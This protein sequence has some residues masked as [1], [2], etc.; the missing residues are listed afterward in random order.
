M[1][2]RVPALRGALLGMMVGDSIGLPFENMSA[3]RV[4]AML[5]SGPLRHRLLWRW[6]MVSD[7]TEHAAMT[8]DAWGRAGGN[9]DRFTRL[10]ARRLRAWFLCI[11]A[12][13]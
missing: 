6:G 13:T 1:S 11:P 9:A 4:H 2:A 3:A 8:V 5:G 7:D 10:L 12:A